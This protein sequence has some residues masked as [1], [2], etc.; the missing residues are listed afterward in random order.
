RA[1]SG[2]AGISGQSP[3]RMT[4][5]NGGLT[6]SV[7]FW[8]HIRNEAID[9]ALG[10]VLANARTHYP[11]EEFGEDQSFGTAIDLN[12]WTSR[13]GSW[14]SPGRHLGRLL[15]PALR[16]GGLRRLGRRWRRS[17][18]C[19]VAGAEQDAGRVAVEIVDGAAD[20]AERAAA[21]GHQCAGALV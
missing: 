21:V 2:P 3:R 1:R 10:V 15:P 14:L 11:R 18:R 7:L 12:R 19:V 6:A 13:Y 4:N 8:G 20:I 9:Q 17:R 16:H 5:E